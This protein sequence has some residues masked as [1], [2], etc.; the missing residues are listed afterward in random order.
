MARAGSAGMGGSLTGPEIR[1][2][3][4]R[5]H[6][7]ARMGPRRLHRVRRAAGHIALL[8]DL[9]VARRG[10]LSAR[11]FEDAIA[12]CNLLPG[13]RRRSCRSSAPGC[14]AGRRAR[15]PAGSPSCCPAWSRC[16]RSGAVPGLLAARRRQRRGGGRRG[17]GRRGG[18][19]GGHPLLRRPP[20]RR[21]AAPRRGSP[22]SSPARRRRGGRAVARARA[23]RGGRWSSGPAGAHARRRPRLAAARRRPVAG[24]AGLDGA[25]GRRAL[26]R[27][28]V[29]D[30]PADA[31]RRGRAPPL[32]ERGAVWNAVAL[33][34]VTPGAV[35]HTGGGG[36]LRGG[37]CRRRA[38]RGGRRVRA[39][40]RLRAVGAR[41]FDAL[42]RTP[43]ARAFLDGAGP[44]A[45]GAILGPTIR[46]RRRSASRGRP[47]CSRARRCC[48]SRWGA[49][50]W[51][52][53]CSRAARGA[54]ARGRRAAAG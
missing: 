36:R 29:R 21:G 46:S 26:L 25:Q 24:G 11:V 40:V 1:G 41:H 7:R 16:S 47:R 34:Q 14:C 39:V 27:R 13:R 48:C 9:C 12:V 51:S 17:G 22:T 4:V 18:A 38:A 6:R 33:G 30:R 52:R 2:V 35:A 31:G 23:A 43:R 15:S 8:R 45:I 49:A 50:S 37:G 5:S 20:A 28:R 10:W 54:R 44:A 32:D 19:T 3:L 53:C 42:R